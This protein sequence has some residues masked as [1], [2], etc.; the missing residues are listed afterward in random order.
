MRWTAFLLL[1]GISG[2]V[3][4]AS[5]KFVHIGMPMQ[6][7]AN[8]LGAPINVVVLDEDTKRGILY[9]R[10][11]QVTVQAGKVIKWKDFPLAKPRANAPVLTLGSTQAAAMDAL[12]WPPAAHEQ[13]LPGGT[14]G[15]SYSFVEVWEYGKS[16]L[17]FLSGRLAGWSNAGEIKVT[18]AEKASNVTPIT[19]GTVKQDAAKAAGTPSVLELRS[20][21]GDEVWRFG[22]DA[23]LFHDG[24][25]VAWENFDSGL[26]LHITPTSGFT[27]MPT[28]GKQQ[29]DV[30]A[31]MGT[32]LAIEP[33]ATRMIWCYSQNAYALSYA[34]MVTEL[35]TPR[36]LSAK[37]AH[38]LTVQEWAAL[39]PWLVA[40]P[41]L[42]YHPEE[43]LT[44][45]MIYQRYLAG[46]KDDFGKF[47][48]EKATALY[49][50]LARGRHTT[51]YMAGVTA[52][53]NAG[54]GEGV[55]NLLKGRA[56]KNYLNGVAEVEKEYRKYSDN[57]FTQYLKKNYTLMP[58]VAKKTVAQAT[59]ALKQVG[60]TAETINYRN[61]EFAPDTVTDTYAPAGYYVMPKS[62]VTLYVS[63]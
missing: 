13:A 3:W 33:Q 18:I 20:V 11:G 23:L 56:S 21:T 14:A 34:G 58:D 7:A 26:P 27:A 29:N 31:A 5:A 35:A 1:L 16:S 57:A 43:L 38:K 9:Y 63:Q 42:D 47:R 41:H 50:T 51:D 37:F 4:A 2:A 28:L 25:V 59:A 54:S 8:I 36:L 24:K 17:T 44:R 6:E 62:M 49:E 61:P 60:L 46:S 12:G 32:P 39:I 19:L 22:A 45:E 40:Q 53:L 15:K 55:A 48:G 10:E 30:V 52:A